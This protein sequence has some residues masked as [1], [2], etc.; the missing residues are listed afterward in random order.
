MGWG[1]RGK[2]IGS[3]FAMDRLFLAFFC[4]SVS[5]CHGNS[6]P[7]RHYTVEIVIVCSLNYDM[8]VFLV[9]LFLG[10]LFTSTFSIFSILFTV[11]VLKKN[12]LWSW[13]LP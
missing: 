3:S 1:G 10:V 8:F 4:I 12:I 9:N 13:G 6:F 11:I 7:R 2:G 5:C